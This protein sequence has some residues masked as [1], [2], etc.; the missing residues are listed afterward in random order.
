M[1]MRLGMA[2]LDMAWED[3][4]ANQETCREL[5]Q[6]AANWG[7]DLLLFPEM[8]LTGFSM[9][10]TAIGEEMANS[11]TKEWFEGLASEHQL[12]L[13]FGMVEKRG[14][15]TKGFNR[16]IIVDKTGQTLLNYAK[17][18]PFAYAGEDR[19][20]EGGDQ[21]VWADYQGW[22]LAP[23]VCFDLRFPEI[24]R[25]AHCAQLH[26]VIANWPLS[27]H[28]QWRALLQARA[29]ENQVYMA[30][31]NRIGIG[32]KIQYGGGSA[33]FGPQGEELAL[34][35]EGLLWFADLDLTTVVA[36]RRNFPFLNDRRPRLYQKLLTQEKKK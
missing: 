22:R 4:A 7:I 19:F 6:K 23:F 2:Q 32:N 27:R 11:S 34:Q 35:N 17:I 24:F 33:I 14:M 18:H 5:V 8:T 1:K 21:V 3:K 16:F 9:N 12:A 30:G 31:V 29:I 20:Y 13:G 15:Q 26:V 36:C 10:I 25:A 28:A